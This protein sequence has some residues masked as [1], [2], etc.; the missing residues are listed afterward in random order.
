M[1]HAPLPAQA[2]AGTVTSSGHPVALPAPRGG[3]RRRTW[4]F[5]AAVLAL[6]AVGGLL[7]PGVLSGAD[8]TTTRRSG[9]TR[10]YVVGED[11]QTSF[12][13]VAVETV[14]RLRGL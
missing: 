7:A 8:D 3:G 5:L 12:G 1:R 10:T 13:V 4:S 6:W 14:Q 9:G 2:E 11:A